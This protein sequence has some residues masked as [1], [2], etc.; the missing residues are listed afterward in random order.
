MKGKI[1]E[2]NIDTK[3]QCTK[4]QKPKSDYYMSY[5]NMHTDGKVPV[6]KACLKG[7]FDSNDMENSLQELLRQIDKPYIHYI[8]ES[9][10]EENP[11]NVFG[12]YMKNVGMKQFRGFT[13]NNSILKPD[14]NSA[15]TRTER[16]DTN[17]YVASDALKDK[18][19]FGYLP[20]EYLAFE[21][22][23]NSLKNNYQQK[24]A[25][26]TE[27][28]ITYIVYKVKGEMA[29]ASNDSKAAKE[30]GTLA[31]DAATAA[32]INPNQ[33]SKSDLSD[34]LDT[35]G[36]L[37]RS[38]EQA[39]DIIEILPRF[40]ERPQDNVDF[41]LWCYINYV[42]DMKGLPL[43]EYEDIYRFYEDRKKEYEKMAAEGEMNGEF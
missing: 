19:G 23:Y 21:R 25:M 28:L 2:T 24:T 42:R 12:T 26:H 35:F 14:F 20:E 40:K 36:Q 39:V 17:S 30:W 29:T 38:V 8:L 18:W 5:S 27:A 33:L 3:K 10:I 16:N 31:K 43:A 1:K 32:K 11:N 9:S 41:T 34:G 15:E 7:M 13:W 22:K 37:V 6:C 4:C